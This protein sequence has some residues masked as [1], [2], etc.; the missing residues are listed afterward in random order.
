VLLVDSNT[1]RTTTVI[2]TTRRTDHTVVVRLPD[3]KAF[4]AVL[5][6]IIIIVLFGFV[7]L[8]FDDYW[9]K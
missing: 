3:R 2:C 7:L 8:L 4:T 1:A 6:D 9:M 5:I